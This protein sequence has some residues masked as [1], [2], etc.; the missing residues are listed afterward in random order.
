MDLTYE[1]HQSLININ[2]LVNNTL[3]SLKRKIPSRELPHVN[4]VT[5]NLSQSYTRDVK[6][7]KFD[8][9]SYFWCT[10]LGISVWNMALILCR[11]WCKRSMWSSLATVESQAISLTPTSWTQ[12]GQ[13]GVL[14][15]FYCRRLWVLFYNM[16]ISFSKSKTLIFFIEKG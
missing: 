11:N 3:I 12:I 2:F 9:K 4:I 7:A 13:M 14:P 8:F 10:T 1:F 16:Y 5:N 15:F 6:I